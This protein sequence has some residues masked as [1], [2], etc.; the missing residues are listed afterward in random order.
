MHSVQTKDFIN[1]E[2][3]VN[4]IWAVVAGYRTGRKGLYV[5]ENFDDDCT[6]KLS[7]CCSI[8]LWLS[9]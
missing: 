6:H 1:T 8:S 5:L 7:I 3:N 9:T 4:S 2:G